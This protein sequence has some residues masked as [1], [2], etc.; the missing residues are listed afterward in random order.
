MHI[1]VALEWPEYLTRHYQ[2]PSLR[3][4]VS[5]N[6]MAE[7]DPVE[8][9]FIQYDRHQLVIQYINGQE[10]AI[11]RRNYSFQEALKQI[12]ELH[13]DFLRQIYRSIIINVDQIRSVQMQGTTAVVWLFDDQIPKPLSYQY[14][15][16]IAEYLEKAE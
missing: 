11:S 5:Y 13:L 15:K 10:L 2:Y 8:I 12:Q 7:I 16:N 6:A 3:L 4:P 9:S 1:G 14:R